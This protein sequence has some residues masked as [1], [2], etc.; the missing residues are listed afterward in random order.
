MLTQAL[1]TGLAPILRVALLLLFILA[2]TAA[3]P[4]EV[5]LFEGGE[6]LEFYQAVAR[7]YERLVP[8]SKVLLEGDP[9]IA[10][11]VRIRIL[12]GHFPAVTNANVNIWSLLEHGHLQP[13]DEWLDGPAWDGTRTWRQSFLPGSLD[14]YSYQ[15]KTYGVPLVYVV[16]SVYY[17]KAVYRE[18]GWSPPQ[19]WPEF[20]EICA[21]AKQRGVAPMAFQGRYSFYAK[22][23]VE[24]NFYHLAGKD[25]YRAQQAAESGSF[26]NPE[27]RQALSLLEEL[28]DNYFQDG[29]LGMS[30]TEAQL[31]FFQGRAAMLMC[32]S[33][34]F[35]E[36]QDN[37]PE[38]FELGAFSL[39]LPVSVQAD[40]GASFASSG[41]LFVMKSSANP[42]G[43]ADFLRYLTSSEVA[44]RFAH[45]QG[46]TVAIGGANGRLNPTVAD[47]AEQLKSIERTFG[48]GAGPSIPGLGQVWTDALSRLLSGKVDAAGAAREMERDAHQVGQAHLNPDRVEIRHPRKTLGFVVLLGLGLVL[49]LAGSSQGEVRGSRIGWPV[50]VGFLLPSLL[51]YTLFFMF[52]SLLALFGGLFRWDGLG[53]PEWVGGLHFQRLLLESD[54]FWIAL[55]NNLILMLAIPALVLPLSLFL[56]N[57]LHHGVW[58]S[59]VFRIAFFFPNLLGVAGILLWQQLYNPQGGP[60]NRILGGLSGQ[61]GLESLAEQPYFEWLSGSFAWL[62]PDHLYYALVPMGVWGACGFNMVLFLAAMQGVPE[63]LY[64]AAELNGANAWQ[65]FIHITVPAIWETLV[66]A[67]IFM[68]IGGMKAFEAIWLLANQAPT[69]DTHVIGTLMVRSMFAEQK[70]GQAAAI[71]CLLFATVL[72][73]S[74]L[75]GRFNR[76][77]VS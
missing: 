25:A 6:G 64:E 11:K 43:G 53:R 56:A 72:V 49:G 66:A 22:A 60:I 59:R 62:S 2:P 65:K 7:E 15:G 32:G 17:N 76:R 18:N 10:D 68:I 73:G 28:A 4:I 16:W 42:A 54:G 24:H 67:I 26:D 58:G 14:Q 51:V 37:I 77:E 13:L 23:L 33:W 19:T 61:F 36:M 29:A 55:G 74:L 44:G 39:P 38:D 71:A 30:H 5:A 20:L 69:T 70:I 48:A 47:V 35:S 12:E 50:R 40:P 52:P 46:I 21:Q 41:Y 1:Q 31:E 3:Q 63:S 9:A 27:M 8:G 45:K 34:L 57:C 75:A